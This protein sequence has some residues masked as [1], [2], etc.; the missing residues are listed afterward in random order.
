MDCR[1]VGLDITDYRTL[2][3]E[4]IGRDVLKWKNTKNHRSGYVWTVAAKRVLRE[5]RDFPLP[6]GAT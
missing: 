1:Y 2:R 5:I 3:D 4:L 6:S